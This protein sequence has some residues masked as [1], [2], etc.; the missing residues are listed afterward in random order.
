MGFTER[1]GIVAFGL[2]APRH[3]ASALRFECH[4]PNRIEKKE[5]KEKK[6]QKMML[7]LKLATGNFQFEC[8]CWK[9][10]RNDCRIDDDAHVTKWTLPMARKEGRFHLIC[11]LIDIIGILI[12]I[13]RS[14]FEG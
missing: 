4:S 13:L 2:I 1:V 12:C 9:W 14:K 3:S 7:K 11:I 8:R 10:R 5:K 6:K